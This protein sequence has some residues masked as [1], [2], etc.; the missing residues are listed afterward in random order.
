MEIKSDV[1][2]L[3]HYATRGVDAAFTELVHRHT[4]LVY[5]AALRQ[6]GSPESAADIAQNVFLGLARDAKA[7]L[8]RFA[9]EAS[10]AGWLCRCTRNLS[11]NFRRDEFRRQ[12]RKRTIMDQLV[13]AHDDALDWEALGRVLDDAM[14][15]LNEPDYD[16]LVLRFY[17]SLDYRAVGAAMGLSD[18]A[19]Q[20]RVNRALNKLR[21]L[22]SQRGIRTSTAALSMVIGANA[23]QA[24]PAGLAISISSAALAGAVTSTSTI[25]A[26][27]KTIAMTTLQKSLVAATVAVLA[28]VEIQQARQSSELRRQVQKLQEQR[29]P[30][31][32]QNQQL[33]L[34]R[35]D[36]TKKLATAR[37]T[38][39]QPSGTMN[40]LIRLRGEVTQLRQSAHELAQLK[41][42]A[43]A[44]GADPAI[45]ATLKSWATRATQLKTRLEQMP[46]KKIPELQLLTEKDWFDAIKNAKQ[47]ETDADYRQALHNLRNSAKQAFG[48]MAKEAIKKYVE[49]NNGALP[50]D[51]SQLKPFFENPVDDA[52]L[53]RYSLL[54]TGNLSDIPPNEYLFAEKGPPVDDE[55]DSHF[56]FGM[57]GTHSSSM[58][59]PGDI[60]WDSLVQFAKSHNGNLP[61]DAPQLI[62]YL[63]RP[64]DQAKVQEILGSI[65]PGI[66]TMEQLKVAGS[67]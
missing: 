23:V 36:L 49:A 38:G 62:P 54:K 26:A 30:L 5:S 40:E 1:Q 35:D 66:K 3:W 34:E 8:P 47:L 4:S 13:T 28:T 24:A 52:T 57:H 59:N 27:T 46:D 33:L 64:L 25:I 6:V 58:N 51:F 63:Q 18:D 60:V 42:A 15:E 39:G 55:F 48:D 12:S 31:A 9:E 53:A 11:L 32:A 29:A 45:E 14:S 41:A 22:L 10:L 37:Q 7:L 21:G 61:A 43:A 17:K 65:P 20:K 50:A 19:A 44:T 56:E 2:L 16:L 67:K